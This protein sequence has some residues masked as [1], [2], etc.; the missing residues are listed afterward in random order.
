[1][2]IPEQP[3]ET[4]ANGHDIEIVLFANQVTSVVMNGLPQWDLPD[5]GVIIELIKG[6]IRV[7]LPGGLSYRARTIT[8]TNVDPKVDS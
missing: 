4:R 6:D 7:R 8:I 1:M 3:Q 2:S 5:P